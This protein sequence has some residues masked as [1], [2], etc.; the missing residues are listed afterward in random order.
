[1]DISVGDGYSFPRVHIS[2]LAAPST[3]SCHLCHCPFYLSL[4]QNEAVVLG[5]KQAHL[6]MVLVGENPASHSYVL[7]KIR[8]AS[9]VGIN[10]HIDE[11]KICNGVSPEILMALSDA[12][13]TISHQYTP[14]EQTKK[15]T[16]L[17][18]IVIS[19]AGI[20]SLITADII[21]EGAALINVG[22]NRV[23][24]PILSKAKL[25]GDVD[26]EGI[27]KNANYITPVWG[28]GPMTVAMLMK[29]TI[30]AA[31]KVLR[32]EEGKY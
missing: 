30:I 15:C 16:V 27:R 1:M 24:D 8:P 32:L 3:Q 2:S 13:V 20:L 22:I 5:N 29:N 18:E 26:F 7:H 28:V 9:E 11:R 21:K 19:A 17:A 23:Q 12:T 10:K 31:K 14:K 25:V 6:S 4:V